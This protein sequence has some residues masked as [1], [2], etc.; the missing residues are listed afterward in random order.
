[1]RK[2]TKLN[3]LQD[4]V[5]QSMTCYSAHEKY[6]VNC[7]RKTCK[8]WINHHDANNCVLIAAQRGK[9]TLQ[10]IGKIYELTRM[11]ICQIE[12]EIFEKIKMNSS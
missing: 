6:G 8:Q 5:V 10:N 3:V 2:K 1:M 9:H 7:E 11:R 4:N 12:K